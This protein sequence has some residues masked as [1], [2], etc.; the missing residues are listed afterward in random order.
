MFADPKTQ[1]WLL[2]LV[3]IKHESFKQTWLPIF[4]EQDISRVPIMFDKDM[5]IQIEAVVVKNSKRQ[6]YLDGMVNKDDLQ[7]QLTVKGSAGVC[8]HF[9][10]CDRGFDIELKFATVRFTSV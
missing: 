7:Y 2:L 10:S 5:Y 6:D 1:E 9:P 4:R 8:L 3:G